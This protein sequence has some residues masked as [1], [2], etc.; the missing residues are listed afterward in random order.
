MMKSTTHNFAMMIYRR[1]GYS[2][3]LHNIENKKV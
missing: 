1:P 2:I 3:P